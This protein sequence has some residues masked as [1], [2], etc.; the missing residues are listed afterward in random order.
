[1]M[2]HIRGE[3]WWI[4]ISNGDRHSSMTRDW[5]DAAGFMAA[6]AAAA[7]DRSIWSTDWPHVQY[8]KP[9]PTDTQLV[10]LL[11]RA[12]PDPELRRKVLCRNPEALFAGADT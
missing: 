4:M 11:Y 10:E 6:I 8:V 12:T 5:D 1:L 3:G 9:M 7:P 2:D